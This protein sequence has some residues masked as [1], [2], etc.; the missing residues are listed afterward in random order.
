MQVTTYPFNSVHEALS[1]FFNRAWVR[2]CRPAEP[3]SLEMIRYQYSPKREDPEVVARAFIAIKAVLDRA[4]NARS[5][6]ILAEHYRKRGA[7]QAE[8]ALHCGL[9]SDRGVRYIRDIVVK[10]LEAVFVKRGI[11]RIPKPGE[12][13]YAREE[14]ATV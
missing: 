4:L 14:G 10:R 1:W 2:N 7:T 3:R 8:V 6:C 12:I 11:V 9:K 5:H 13:K